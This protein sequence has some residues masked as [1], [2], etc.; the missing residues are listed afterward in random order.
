VVR[1]IRQSEWE[2]GQQLAQRRAHDVEPPTSYLLHS[3]P[4]RR[5]EF[6]DCQDFAWLALGLHY[7]Q[8]RHTSHGGRAILTQASNDQ[9]HGA[10]FLSSHIRDL[11]FSFALIDE[12][13]LN[14]RWVSGT[15]FCTRW[16]IGGAVTLISWHS[17]SDTQEPHRTHDRQAWLLPEK[18]AISSASF[19]DTVI[20][21][22]TSCAVLSRP[23][24]PLP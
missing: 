5:L 22:I 24:P 1:R 20:E 7:T 8:A 3:S 9:L 16:P 4:L 13:C 23:P 21:R 19:L 14:R 15:P 11:K 2:K 12:H 17:V 10:V 6:E 18:T